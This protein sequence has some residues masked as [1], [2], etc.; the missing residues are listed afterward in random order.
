MAIQTGITPP[1][2]YE[3]QVEMQKSADRLELFIKPQGC[4]VQTV[5]FFSFFFFFFIPFFV[6]VS[7]ALAESEG[8]LW[9]LGAGLSAFVWILLPF[10]IYKEV[11][12]AWAV[13]VEDGGQVTVREMRKSATIKERV[14]RCSDMEQ[15]E[16]L[17]RRHVQG[18]HDSDV[19]TVKRA[20]LIL[21]FPGAE[22]FLDRKVIL[23]HNYA[24]DDELLDWMAR[25]I[26]Q[27]ASVTVVIPSYESS[28][29][30]C[31]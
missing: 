4:S 23:F 12:T 7:L 18:R 19:T 21:D 17:R 27:Q 29:G 20:G 3:N 5:T 26:G 15:V 28:S 16:V 24:F 31:S 30:C 25:E 1:T 13:V 11:T 8:R 22:N 2:L 10:A 14:W 6:F 9:Y